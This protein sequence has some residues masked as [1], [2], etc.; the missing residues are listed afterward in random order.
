MG[1]EGRRQGGRSGEAQKGWHPG[2]LG[3]LNRPAKACPPK[4]GRGQG[5]RR[6]VECRGRGKRE[7]QER[8]LEGKEAGMGYR[9]QKRSRINRIE[10]KPS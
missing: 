8:A 6:R 1:R 5:T 10:T 7:G 2:D 9:R 3:N 4:T